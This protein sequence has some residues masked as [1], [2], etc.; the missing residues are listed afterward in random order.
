M[1]HCPPHPPP[2]PGVRVTADLSWGTLET[3]RQYL[4]GCWKNPTALLLGFSVKGKSFK[5]EGEEMIPLEL[6]P[7]QENHEPNC[8][9]GIATGS[10]LGLK[11]KDSCWKVRILGTEEEQSSGWK[12]CPLSGPYL[13]LRFDIITCSVVLTAQ[14]CGF[15]SKL[16]QA[17][18]SIRKS[19]CE[20]M[21]RVY[22][23]RGRVEWEVAE[24]SS[25]R[26]T[27]ISGLCAHILVYSKKCVVWS[28]DCWPRCLDNAALTPLAFP[29]LEHSICVLLLPENFHFASLC[30]AFCFSTFNFELK[31]CLLRRCFPP[32]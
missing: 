1:S 19:V 4:L 11:G 30:M 21:P 26:L 2:S 6:N 32:F 20:V 10:S 7:S 3:G 12:G 25:M 24:S 8:T 22:F 23:L 13:L 16:S 15:V 17:H 18:E 28:L 27:C 29:F 14:P 31:Y 5:P 9:I